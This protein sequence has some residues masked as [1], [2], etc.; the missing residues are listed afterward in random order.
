LPGFG[1][2]RLNPAAQADPLE[3]VQVNQDIS[4]GVV[5]SDGSSIA[6]FGSLYAERHSLT[7]DSLGSGALFV[8][9]FVF[10]AVPVKL[11]TQARAGT[12]G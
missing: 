12:G 6:Q 4:Q 7:V 11:I 9:G 8:N 3:G 10:L 5:I 1:F 2:N